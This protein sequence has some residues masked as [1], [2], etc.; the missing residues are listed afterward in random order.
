MNTLAEYKSIIRLLNSVPVVVSVHCIVSADNCCNLAYADFIH[1]FDSLGNK[2][3]TRCRRNVSTVHNAVKINLIL[4]ES[5]CKLNESKNVAVVRMNAAV[6]HKSH[7]M[8][9]LACFNRF[10]NGVNE[11]FIFKKVAV[12]DRFCYSCKLLINYSAGAHICVPNL[13]VT[14]LTVGKTYI[15]SRSADIGIRILLHK[16]IK[17]WLFCGGNSI[18]VVARIMTEAVH[19]TKYISLFHFLS[20]LL[21]RKTGRVYP[22]PLFII[23]KQPLRLLKNRL[24]LMKRRR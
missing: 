11:R 12:L 14:H 22:L 6:G 1:F 5:L 17:I 20:P 24:P 8:K 4:T 2:I 16:H 19:Y 7:K 23:L 3:L 13:G 10:F 9:R 21:Y 18:S 15:K